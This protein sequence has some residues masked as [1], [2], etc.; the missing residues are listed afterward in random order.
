MNELMKNR[1]IYTFKSC[2]MLNDYTNARGF[3]EL[4][5]SCRI[6]S[7]APGQIVFKEGDEGDRFYLIAFGEV[8]VSVEGKVVRRLG[9]GKYFGEIA[10]ATEIK[11][12]ATCATKCLTLLLSIGKKDFKKLLN[13]G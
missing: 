6:E 8:E 7:Y 5:N 1:L 3:D 4:A 10:L 11:R 2:K 13:C 9:R 12:T